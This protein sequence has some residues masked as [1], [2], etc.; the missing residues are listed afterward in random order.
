[1]NITKY[2]ALFS[3]AILLSGVVAVTFSFFIANVQALEE[4]HFKH[5]KVKKHT[6]INLNFVI[7]GKV[8]TKTF[9]SD[10]PLC[11]NNNRNNFD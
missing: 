1:M 7:D 8:I 9:N 4:N 11:V 6:C 5:Y 10:G 2:G 3:V